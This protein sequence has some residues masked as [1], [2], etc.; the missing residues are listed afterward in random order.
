[1]TSMLKVTADLPGLAVILQFVREA[2]VQLDIDRA[3]IDDMLQAVDEAA[4]N[5]I[6]HGYQGGPGE[7][8]LEVSRENEALVVRLRDQARLFDPTQVPPPDLTLPFE[9]RRF[10]GLGVYLA[11]Q[12]T[13]AMTYAV[14]PE[15]G[16]ELT[17]RKNIG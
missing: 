12:F 17:L 4:T 7:M 6:V 15:G 3:V 14:T 8:E 5:V 9:Q 16:N 13:D 10:G 11:R 2:A 1:M